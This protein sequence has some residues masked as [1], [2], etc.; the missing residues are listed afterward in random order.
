PRVAADDDAVE[1]LVRSRAK[2]AGEA[3]DRRPELGAR[4][5]A[6]EMGVEQG[7]LERGQLAV[8]LQRRPFAGALA[9]SVHASHS[10]SDAADFQKL[11]PLI[12]ENRPNLQKIECLPSSSTP[13]AT[14]MM[15]RPTRTAEVLIASSCSPRVAQ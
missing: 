3:A 12:T 15:P 10:C 5:A 1:A 11:A 4:P 9:I 13:I 8:Q 2:R 6:L 7:A 14:R